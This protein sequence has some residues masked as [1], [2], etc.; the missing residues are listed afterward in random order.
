MGIMPRVRDKEVVSRL[1]SALDL[2]LERKTGGGL[3]LG[4]EPCQMAGILG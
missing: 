2:K 1:K 4:R 3:E